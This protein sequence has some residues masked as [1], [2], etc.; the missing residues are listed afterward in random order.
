MVTTFIL[1]GNFFAKRGYRNGRRDAW[2]K[3]TVIIILIIIII[4]IEL[5]YFAPLWLGNFPTG[6]ALYWY[7]QFIEDMYIFVKYCCS[8][9]KCILYC[10]VTIAY[11]INMK[12]FILSTA[13]LKIFLVKSITLWCLSPLAN[14]AT[15]RLVTIS[16]Y[17]YQWTCHH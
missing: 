8:P 6:L 12:F 3:L 11:C 14:I 13:R 7:P 10:I 9:M 17:C 5:V 15:N 4:I 1:N 16:K 2:K